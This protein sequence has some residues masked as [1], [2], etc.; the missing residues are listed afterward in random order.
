MAVAKEKDRQDKRNNKLAQAFRDTRAELKK[1][2][3]PSREE[4]MRLTI[5][6]I[7][8][9]SVIGTLLFISDSIFLYLYTLLA[10]LV[11]PG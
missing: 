1:V 7:I 6:V 8:V 3:W 5:L 2:V 4:A 9:A 10:D 11:S